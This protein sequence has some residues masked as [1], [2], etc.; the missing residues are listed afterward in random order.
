MGI[1]NVTPDSFFDGGKY[2]ALDAAL[3]R[4]EMMVSEGADIIDVGGE[5]S[6]PGS[7]FISVPEELARTI[8]IIQKLVHRFPKIPI[9]IDTQK[10]EVA[11]RALDEGVAIVNDISALRSDAKMADLV[12]VWRCDIILM[13]MRG[14]PEMMQKSPRYRNVVQ[15]V[16]S[17]LSER[18]RFAVRRGISKSKIWIDPGIGFGKTVEHN[19]NLLADLNN[20]ESLDAP[21]LVGVSRK[22][23]IGKLT[24][25]RGPS[26]ALEDRLPGSLALAAWSFLQ[27]AS[28]LRVHDVSAT[29][30]LLRVLEQIAKIRHT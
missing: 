23:F 20:F 28:V 19:L 7:K 27:G 29:K 2:R 22:S 6:R 16:K 24:G 26:A 4:A 3:A 18:I 21:V 10:S 13:H 9:S 17:F 1:L 5:S 15:E 30:N 8:P 11:A 25:S 12:R 14:T